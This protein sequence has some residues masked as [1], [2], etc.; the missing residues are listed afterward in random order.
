MRDKEFPGVFELEQLM[1]KLLAEGLVRNRI[2]QL[3]FPM[4]RLACRSFR[5]R[6]EVLIR[7]LLIPAARSAQ[8]FNITEGRSEELITEAMSHRQRL[9]DRRE[10]SSR[11][12]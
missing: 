3:P 7:H 2:D 9:A 12:S 4:E 6:H 10:I 8:R 5:R 1:G 11:K